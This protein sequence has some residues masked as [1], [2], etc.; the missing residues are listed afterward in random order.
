MTFPDQY[1]SL[2]DS[3]LV[4]APLV[5]IALIT[6]AEIESRGWKNRA[7]ANLVRAEMVV[8]EVGF[9]ALFGAL[10]MVYGFLWGNL[11]SVVWVLL[12]TLVG[13]MGVV[14]AVGYPFAIIWKRSNGAIEVIKARKAPPAPLAALEVSDSTPNASQLVNQCQSNNL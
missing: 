2:L 7:S 10:A 11:M 5:L 1:R 6:F 13:A 8:I 9:F 12:F 3:T 14:I 4:L